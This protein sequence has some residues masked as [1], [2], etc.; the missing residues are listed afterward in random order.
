VLGTVC[1]SNKGG[2]STI[3]V[4]NVAVSIPGY[5]PI[6]PQCPASTVPAGG[7]MTCT[8]SASLGDSF[9]GTEVDAS[10]SVNNVPISAVGTLEVDVGAIQATDVSATLSD[11][12]LPIP[13]SQTGF[14]SDGPHIVTYPYTFACSAG[15]LENSRQPVKHH[16]PNTATLVTIDTHTT[17]TASAFVDYTCFPPP[18]PGCVDDDLTSPPCVLPIKVHQQ[19]LECTPRTAFVNN[20]DGNCAS[21]VISDHCPPEFPPNP[22]PSGPPGGNP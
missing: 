9:T 15:E 8:F 5:G 19:A 11:S 2:V 14:S 16:V 13:S 6:I 1:I 7:L 12:L 3:S 18:A 22:L 21:L 20:P 10:A 17:L 4:S